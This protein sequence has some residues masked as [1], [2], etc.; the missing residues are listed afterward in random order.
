MSQEVYEAAIHYTKTLGWLVHPV[1][2]R[3]K[4]PI[5]HDWAKR[6][7]PLTDEELKGYFENGENN[8]GVL[9]GVASN[10]TVIDFDDMLFYD[11]IIKG[12]DTSNWLSSTR[13]KE[14]EKGGRG[15]LFFKHEPELVQ[16]MGRKLGKRDKA[17]G[18]EP[19]QLLGIDILSGNMNGGGSNVVIAPSI[20]PSGNKYR[21]SRDIAGKEDIPAF[22]RELKERLQH[23]IAIEEELYKSILTSR[24]WI[25]EI[26]ARG[27]KE[28][29]F[30]GG[31]GRLLMIALVAE[32]KKNG[33]SD[34]GIHFLSKV[35]Y[36]GGYDARRTEQELKHVKP[37]PWTSK[38]LCE[39]FAEFCNSE[40]TGRGDRVEERPKAQTPIVTCDNEE[41]VSLG[42]VNENG[43]VTL[44]LRSIAEYLTDKYKP[45]FYGER[46][47]IYDVDEGIYQE[48]EGV[49]RSKYAEIAKSWNI[50]S[51]IKRSCEE[52]LNWVQDTCRYYE[53]PFNNFEGLIPVKNGV[54]KVDYKTGCMELLPHSHTYKFK[55]KIQI[56]YIPVAPDTIHEEMIKRYVDE[57]FINTLYQIPAQA[58]RQVSCD[59]FKKAYMLQGE[60]NAGK[61]TYLELIKTLFGIGVI[62]G[63]S[64][65]HLGES[66][67]AK[68]S[69]EGKLLNIYDDVSEIPMRDTGIFKTLTG[70]KTHSIERKGKQAYTGIISAVH[71]YTCN[72]PPSFDSRVKKDTAFWDR[73]E[74]V[75]FPY[76]F[77]KDENF[78][79]RMFTR[80]NLAGFLNRVLKMVIEIY[81]N[82]LKVNSTAGEVRLLWSLASDPIHQYIKD[83]IDPNKPGVYVRKAEFMNCVQRYCIANGVDMEKLPKSLT[84]F[85]QAIDK[86]EIFPEKKTNAKTGVREECYSIPGGFVS[87]SGF[88]PELI[89]VKTEQ[90]KI[91]QC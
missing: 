24:Q 8:I 88:V 76:V 12:M 41:F 55:Y 63:E 85:T 33:L 69:L 50:E 1:R 62:S 44:L 14:G 2:P 32:L 89:P 86:Y 5:P 67:F 20:H 83:T 81:N 49:L 9:C 79:R 75:K 35:I 60:P 27:D 61:S 39:E 73:W 7:E 6:T 19:A 78:T 21:F 11:D 46:L 28:S 36:R 80:E 45:I 70:I 90:A 34:D 3:D 56:D 22:P 13:G 91:G 10:L 43:S 48:G 18:I 74:Y 53:N 59:P 29:I 58:I 64:L 77:E 31:N 57:E 17:R 52:V 47:Y 15:H 82:G 87:Y 54:L 40:N 68:A 23:F 25:K 66:Y 16:R 26:I 4:A 30:H 65:Q 51:G 38:R 37:T 72:V 71:V 42:R 84:G